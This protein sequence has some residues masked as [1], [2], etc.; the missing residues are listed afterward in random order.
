MRFHA[1]ATDYDGTIA[2]DGN[3]DEA[4]IVALERAQ[5]IGPQARAR[6]RPR[7][8]RPAHRLPAHRPLRQAVIENGATVYDPNDEGN[9]PPGRAAAAEFRG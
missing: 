7:T 2:H 8:A 3:V 6:D 4:T 5:E 1:L 9:A